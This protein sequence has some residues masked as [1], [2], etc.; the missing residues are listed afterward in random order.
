[1]DPGVK[2]HTK[3]RHCC[4]NN[5]TIEGDILKFKGE[6]GSVGVLIILEPI[7]PMLNYFE[8]EV[9]SRGQKCA[10]GLGFGDKNYSLD[11]MPGWNV[12]GIGYHDDDGR[13]FHHDGRGTQF[14]PT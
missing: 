9:V 13:L 12:N 4:G 10:I 3:G 5:A 1:M 6:R 14:G 2:L 8:C 7:N 11:H